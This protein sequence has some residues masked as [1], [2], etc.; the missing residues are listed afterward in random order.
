[1]G[2]YKGDARRFR[3]AASSSQDTGRT[4]RSPQ[5]IGAAVFYTVLTFL[6]ESVL[7][8]TIYSLGIMICFYYGLT[9]FGCIW[10]FR[11]TSLR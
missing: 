9:A 8:D 2:A 3:Q 7:T 1:M 4:P 6:S 10:F 11:H 5:D